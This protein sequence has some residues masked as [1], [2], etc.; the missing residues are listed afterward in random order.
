MNY[1]IIDQLA[2]NLVDICFDNT[3]QI[4]CKSLLCFPKIGKFNYSKITKI[5]LVK[6]YVF[7]FRIVYLAQFSTDFNILDLKI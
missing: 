3:L 7:Y 4:L 6:F 1:V 5:W 2:S